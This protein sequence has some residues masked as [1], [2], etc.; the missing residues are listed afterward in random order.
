MDPDV[1]KRG[2]GGF[3]STDINDMFSTSSLSEL[4]TLR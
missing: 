3:G 1:S 2:E 4:S